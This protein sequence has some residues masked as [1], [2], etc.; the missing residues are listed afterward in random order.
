MLFMRVGNAWG[1]VGSI[2]DVT[3]LPHFDNQAGRSAFKL[4]VGFAMGF[5]VDEQWSILFPPSEVA[6]EANWEKGCAEY[7]RAVSEPPRS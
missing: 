7:A 3:T 2:S 4:I 5:A 6:D 1:D